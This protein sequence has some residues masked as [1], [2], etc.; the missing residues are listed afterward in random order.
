V[1]PVYLGIDFLIGPGLQL[2]VT[3]VNVG[4]PGGAEEH[5]RAHR[6]R[7]GRPSGI[8]ARI[9]EISRRVYGRPFADYL[10]S[11]PF[12]PAL[13]AFKLWMDGRGPLP[14]EFHPALRLEDKWVQYQVLSR[15]VPMPETA[16]FDPESLGTASARLANRGCLVLKRRLGR[17]GRGF[18]IIR[19]LED[20]PAVAAGPPGPSQ[21]LQ[22]YIDSRVGGFAFS[23]RA[24]AFGGEFVCAY[25]NLARRE[26]SNHG[27]LTLVV[28]GESFGLSDPDFRTERFDERSW[29]AKLWFGESEPAYLRHN[30]YEDTVASAPVLLP[31]PLLA[32]LAGTA[33]KIERVY[34]ALDFSALP[35]AVFE[36]SGR[37]SG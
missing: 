23:I 17:G 28:E 4:L 22:E 12:L 29:E 36:E 30:L 24:V 20:L 9:E 15:V 11:L 6:V 1:T 27:I 7:H 32:A 25:A 10:G 2:Y 26:H 37:N 13:K 34:E 21:L 8:F 35:A 16:V 19:R 18:R 33:A 31:R 14:A 5:D 3:E